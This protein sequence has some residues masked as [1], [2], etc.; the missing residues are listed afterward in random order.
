MSNKYFFDTTDKAEKELEEKKKFLISKIEKMTL[1]DIN[2][3]LAVIDEI[4][5][6]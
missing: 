3:L 5:F 1:N 6:E 2:K 4:T